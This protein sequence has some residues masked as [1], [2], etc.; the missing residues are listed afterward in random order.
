MIRLALVLCALAIPFGAAAQD[1]GHSPYAGLEDREIKS[2]SR[3]DLDD[4]REGR[5]WGL[6]LPAELNGV[7]GP[8]HLL[9]LKNELA[10]DARQ[11]ASIEAVFAKMQAEA[12]AAGDRFIAAEAAIEAAFRRGGPD[13]DTLRVLIDAAAEA[14]AELRFV[15]L[16]RHL[17]TLP[18]LTDRQIA[19]YNALRGYGA[20]DPCDAV[21]DGHDPGMWRRHNNC[22]N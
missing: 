8:A 10:L 2:L 17:E 18:L 13:R 19:S 21:P 20:P 12:R 22:G 6:A 4:L 1:H 7:P 9:E 16:S 3:A 14:R 11:V 15:H 5:G